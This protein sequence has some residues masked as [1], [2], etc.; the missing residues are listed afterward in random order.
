MVLKLED[1]CLGSDY[2]NASFIDVSDNP[3]IHVYSYTACMYLIPYRVTIG[4]MH[5]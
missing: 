1:K 2:I 4:G 5:T 3:V